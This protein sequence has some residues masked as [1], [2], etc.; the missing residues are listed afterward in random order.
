VITIVYKE[1]VLGSLPKKQF[2][3][4]KSIC[5]D[6]NWKLKRIKENLFDLV[7]SHKEEQPQYIYYLNSTSHPF[8]KTIAN[9]LME[10][11]EILNIKLLPIATIEEARDTA[12]IIDVAIDTCN[13]TPQMFVVLLDLENN[14]V[15]YS[16]L[17]LSGLELE[18]QPNSNNYLKLKINL[19]SSSNTFEQENFVTEALVKLSNTLIEHLWSQTNEVDD[20][21]V[22][23]LFD[24]MLNEQYTTY[25][26]FDI[27]PQTLTMLPKE[28]ME[29]VSIKT[30]YDIQQLDQTSS[31]LLVY[32][33]I[34]NNSTEKLVNP[35]IE[36][37][38]EPHKLMTLCSSFI[39]YNRIKTCSL[40]RDEFPAG[41]CFKTLCKNQ[42][43]KLLLSPIN[44]L[45]LEPKESYVV[46]TI[47]FQVNES[48]EI[49]LRASISFA[50]TN[51]QIDLTIIK[52]TSKNYTK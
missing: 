51:N 41:W 20:Q 29:L 44:A 21:I 25:P 47:K 10:A 42:I 24:V 9:T 52:P 13:E 36:L 11:L 1:D 30:K 7:S 3:L 35:K 16:N 34:I 5:R 17:K 22:K 18:H 39:P 37:Q 27:D 38:L 28:L 4:F 48:P 14:N 50:N 49:D 6:R 40:Y 15:L 32:L 19:P 33:E 8:D 45:S 2:Y 26:S 46:P 31:L 43:N 23:K 12:L